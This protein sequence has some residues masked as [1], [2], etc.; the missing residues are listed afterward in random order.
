M[1]RSWRYGV[2]GVG[3]AT[4]KDTQGISSPHRR[5]DALKSDSTGQNIHLAIYEKD[6]KIVSVAAK[7]RPGKS[8]PP[9]LRKDELKEFRA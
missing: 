1:E 9:R 3:S 2:P 4:N 8:Q 6:I 7:D 5:S